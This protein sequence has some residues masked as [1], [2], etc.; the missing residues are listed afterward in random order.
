MKTHHRHSDDALI[1][2]FKFET[3]ETRRDQ[4]LLRLVKCCLKKR[5]P[6]M[7]YD[8]FIFNKG[9]IERDTRQSNHLRLPFVRLECTKKSFFFFCFFL[10]IMVLLQLFITDIY[11]FSFLYI[12]RC[13]YKLFLIF[14][15]Y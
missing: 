8:Y 7:F 10:F 3:L 11:N 13:I 4:Q 2:Y 12:Y 6:Q 5:C 15:I 9:V 1:K 14:F